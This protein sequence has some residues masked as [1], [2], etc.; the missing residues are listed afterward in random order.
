MNYRILTS[1]CVYKVDNV[2]TAEIM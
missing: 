2:V 1:S